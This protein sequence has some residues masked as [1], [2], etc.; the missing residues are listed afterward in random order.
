M[1]KSVAAAAATVAPPPFTSH[2]PL[3]DPI[4]QMRNII[5]YRR[6]I[7]KFRNYHKHQSAA[8]EQIEEAFRRTFLRSDSLCAS[9]I[10]L[11]F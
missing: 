5:V 9:V 4:I 11:H 10:L 3:I 7:G 6:R 1:S 8:V 2:S